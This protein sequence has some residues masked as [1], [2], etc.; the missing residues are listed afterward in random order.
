M[1]F[2]GPGSY[3]KTGSGG[4]LLELARRPHLCS[5]APH[6]ENPL[7]ETDGQAADARREYLGRDIKAKEKERFQQCRALY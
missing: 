6:L 4:G 2:G 7:V 1:H 5:L 3:E